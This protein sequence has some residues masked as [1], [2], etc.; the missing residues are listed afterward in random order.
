MRSAGD[1][2]HRARAG[3]VHVVWGDNLAKLAPRIGELVAADV[4]GD[5]PVAARGRDHAP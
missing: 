4:V 5:T 1:G 3:A 2:V